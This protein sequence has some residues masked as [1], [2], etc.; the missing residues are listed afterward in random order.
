LNRK[1]VKTLAW[2][3]PEIKSFNPLLSKVQYRSD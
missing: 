3:V 1:F 2:L